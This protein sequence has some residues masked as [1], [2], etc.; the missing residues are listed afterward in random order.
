MKLK[1]YPEYKDSGVEWI[2]EIPNKWEILKSGLIFNRINNPSVMGNE[3]LLSV[4][5]YYGIKPRKEVIDEGDHITNANS[6]VGYKK[7]SK[8]DLV[9]N[10]MLAWKKGLAISHYDGIVSPAYEVFNT[11][12]A[13]V[14]PQ[15][16]H[17]L[18]RTDM[19]A[20]EFERHSY[21]II[22]SRLRLYPDNFKNIKVILPPKDHQLKIAD[23][24]DKKTSEI[25]LI[26]EKET[27]LIEF[28]KEKRTALINHVVAKGRDSTVKMKDSGVKWIGEIPEDWEKKKIKHLVHQI[29]DTE[30][31]TA[32][33][34]QD[35]KYLVVRTSNIRDGE[36]I[37]K[38]AKYTNYEAFKLWTR[39]GTPKYGDIMFTRE[40]PAGEACLV[41][42]D[43]NLCIGQR[44]VL[45][46]VDKNKLNGQFGVYSLY[47]GVADQFIS[48]L[49]QGSTVTHF[50]MSDIGNIPLV[51]PSIEEQENIVRYLGKETSKINQII[52]KV[53]KNINLLEEYKKSLI[54]H[55]VTGKVDVRE[56]AV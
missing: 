36:L 8:D 31:K 21:G 55:V 48:S 47:A 49:S 3:T 5:E 29:I 26:I 52:N 9:M 15:Y 44:I 25:D 19:Y 7:C 17:Y 22:K 20:T 32:P 16:M 28:L 42:Q 10:I 33:F 43:V 50:N 51:I 18:L 37:L 6:L 53:G 4:S 34:Y 30:H 2:G 23:F 27:Q 35:G 39:R 45:F 12:S 13:I 56:V 38:D 41:P 24:L 54:H 1:P 46:K 14:C 40:A 11:N